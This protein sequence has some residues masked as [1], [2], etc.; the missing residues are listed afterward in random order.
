MGVYTRIS[1]SSLL[2]HRV[3]ICRIPKSRHK[4][5]DSKDLSTP[6]WVP[7][8]PTLTFQYLSVYF[9]LLFLLYRRKEKRGSFYFYNQIAVNIVV[10]ESSFSSI[11]LDLELKYSVDLTTGFYTT[12]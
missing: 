1:H 7:I 12:D 6:Q 2:N 4:V 9:V 8:I 11:S 10:N 5:L 3:Q